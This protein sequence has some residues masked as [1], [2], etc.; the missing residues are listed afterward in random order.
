MS[1]VE[2]ITGV[3]RRRY[4]TDE[5]K[6][7]IVAAAFAP[8]A[9]V[10]D[11]ARQADVGRE[12]IYRWRRAFKRAEAGFSKVIVAPSTTLGGAVDPSVPACVATGS[13]VIEVLLGNG[14]QARILAS[15][16][17]ELAAAVIKALMR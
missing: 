9:S 6:R 12:A 2:V 5:Q 11:V 8:G 3:Q 16:P 7:E 4:W 17:P 1:R 10:A 14:G 15:T 13:P